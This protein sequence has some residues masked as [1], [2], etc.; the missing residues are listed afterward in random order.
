MNATWLFVPG[1]EPR[2]LRKALLSAADVVIVDWEDGVPLDQKDAARHQT[3]ELLAQRTAP[4]QV[5]VRVNGLTTPWWDDDLRIA[6][7]LNPTAVMVP[8]AEDPAAIAA[9]AA[10]GMPII[11]LV[12][13]A[14]GLEQAVALGR[15]H[16]LVTHLALG[17]LDLLADLG[18]RWTP[19]GE[20][21]WYARARLVVAARA[22]G[23]DGMIDGVYPDL[24][25]LDGLRHDAQSARTLG[26]T[27]KM[28]LHPRQIE[29]VREAFQPTSAEIQQAR[30][31]IEAAQDAARAHRAALQVNGLFVDPP[32]VRRAHQILQSLPATDEGAADVTTAPGA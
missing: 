21:L 3:R 28:V 20:A 6:R 27:G 5:V 10:L 31:I 18:A 1:H 14:L 26:C 25:D 17:P 19:Q 4:R 32:V 22:A 13:S 24:A 11:P 8:K 12:E 9:A 23:L 29:V 15:A 16:P 30:A 2:K 7:S